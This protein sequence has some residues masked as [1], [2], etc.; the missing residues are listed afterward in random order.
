[1][2]L[3][4]TQDRAAEAEPAG[5]PHPQGV[6][7]RYRWSV[8]D[9]V[10]QILSQLVQPV[11]AGA[12]GADEDPSARFTYGQGRTFVTTARGSIN[13]ARDGYGSAIQTTQTARWVAAPGYDPF[14]LPT[15]TPAATAADSGQ[16][17]TPRIPQLPRFGY[18]GELTRGPMV[19]LRARFYDSAAGR[20]VSRDPVRQLGGPSQAANP[21]VYANNDPLDFIDPLGTQPFGLSG[22]LT[23]IERILDLLDPCRHCPADPG[24]SIESHLKCLQ[25]KACL[26]TRGPADPRQTGETPKRPCVCENAQAE[27]HPLMADVRKLFLDLGLEML[28]ACLPFPRHQS[29]TSSISQLGSSSRYSSTSTATRS[30]D[31]W[32]G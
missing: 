13:L 7:V 3:S 14:G 24:N 23:L 22:L 31:A 19:Y 27:R 25:G 2:T 9:T 30:T 16:H 29:R 18:R 10:P 17:P 4:A 1:V 28:P 8:G 15:A 32:T 26:Y 11:G 20:F 6:S 5:V 21:Y 12:F